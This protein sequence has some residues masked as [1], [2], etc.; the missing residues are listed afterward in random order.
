MYLLLHFHV[1]PYLWT[2]LSFT[3][4]VCTLP[5]IRSGCDRPRPAAPSCYMPDFLLQR[6]FSS[7][8][9]HT[10]LSGRVYC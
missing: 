3:G 10:A 5:A 6:F 9:T 7:Y 1:P 8:L 2:T 4:V